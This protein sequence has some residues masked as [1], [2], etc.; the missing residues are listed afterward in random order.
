MQGWLRIQKSIN[1]IHRINRKKI[2][3]CMIVSIDAEKNLNS[4]SFHDKFSQKLDIEGIYI[5]TMKAM[6]DKLTATIILNGKKFEV[7][8][9]LSE[10][11]SVQHSIGVLFMQ[12]GKR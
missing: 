8:P 4:T 7:F 10:T 5:N 12:L 3:T 9:L 6:Y 11:T 1:M 2:K